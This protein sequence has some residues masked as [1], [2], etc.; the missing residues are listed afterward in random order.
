MGTSPEGELPLAWSP[1]SLDSSMHTSSGAAVGGNGVRSGSS[2]F[3]P[4]PSPDGEPS[5]ASVY[6]GAL[7]SGSCFASP[8]ISPRV[9]W[10]S[11]RAASLFHGLVHFLDGRSREIRDKLLHDDVIERSCVELINLTSTLG[12]KLLIRNK[13]R[14]SFLRKGRSEGGRAHHSQLL[15]KR[16]KDQ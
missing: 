12:T 14:V 13:I 5:D 6:I 10:C 8:A 16:C 2:T 3:T 11:S 1:E 4:D 15:V 9:R 7:G